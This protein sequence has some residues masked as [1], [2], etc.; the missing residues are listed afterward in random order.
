MMETGHSVTRAQFEA[1]LHANAADREFRGD[2]LPLLRPGK[3]GNFEAALAT[4]QERLIQRLPG[5]PWR[6]ADS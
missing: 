2:V 3:E 1:N 6:G 4:V 5:A